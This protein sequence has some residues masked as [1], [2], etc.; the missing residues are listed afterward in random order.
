MGFKQKS[1]PI[2]TLPFVPAS[3]LQ[4]YQQKSLIHHFYLTHYWTIPKNTTIDFHQLYGKVTTENDHPSL[5]FPLLSNENDKVNKEL[6]VFQRV[7]S[8]IKCTNYLGP[9]CI[10]AASKSDLNTF[11][12]LR[13]VQ[14]DGSY[15]CGLGL[16]QDGS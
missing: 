2:W 3:H 7:H 10:Y 8:A 12:L 6:L 16:F 14:D 5:K 13:R 4:D 1:V 11:I 9:R 15:V